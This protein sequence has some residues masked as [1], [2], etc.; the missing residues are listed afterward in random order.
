VLVVFLAAGCAARHRPVVDLTTSTGQN[1]EYDL[2]QC[3]Q[4]ASQAPGIGTGAVGGVLAG[5]AFGAIVGA[6][7][8]DP[9]LG[10]ALGAASGGLGGASGG[11]A[12]QSNAVNRCMAGRGY[13]ILW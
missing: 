6:I 9:G 12:A 1:Y 4:L 3:Q 13:T 10:A 5:A 8:G 11:V 2:A 7:L